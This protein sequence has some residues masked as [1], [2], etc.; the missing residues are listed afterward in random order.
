M[1]ILV[2]DGDG[3]LAPSCIVFLSYW[4]HEVEVV[5]DGLAALRRARAW[6]PDVLVARVLLDGMDGYALTAAVRADARLRDTAVVLAGA[7]SDGSARRRA[8]LL[9]ASRYLATP[10]AVPE[11]QRVVGALARRHVHDGAARPRRRGVG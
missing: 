1:R 8:A 5:H 7:A 10:L 11:L 4:G 3:A 2:A 6:S 9:G